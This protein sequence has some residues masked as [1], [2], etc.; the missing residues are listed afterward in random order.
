MFPSTLQFNVE[1][2]E[3]GSTT[4]TQVVSNNCTFSMMCMCVIGGVY[5][6]ISSSDVCVCVCPDSGAE[7]CVPGVCVLEV[8]LQCC[9][10]TLRGC[11]V[12][13]LSC[14]GLPAAWQHPDHHCHHGDTQPGPRCVLVGDI[15]LFM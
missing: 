11:Q 13:P 12:V 14:R 4:P 6:L 9:V 15:S 5:F 3:P 7:E 1:L 10:S 8:G 2:L